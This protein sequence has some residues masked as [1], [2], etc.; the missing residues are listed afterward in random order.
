M[1]FCQG[2]DLMQLLIVKN[3]FTDADTKFYMSELATAINEIHKLNFAHRDLKP[4]NVLIDAAGH[5][6]LT[7]FGLC[8]MFYEH[9]DNEKLIEAVN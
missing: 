5:L 4:D 2:G 8:S 7:D 1:D 3:R 9:E 6:K